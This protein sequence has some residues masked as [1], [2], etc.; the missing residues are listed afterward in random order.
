MFGVAVLLTSYIALAVVIGVK[1]FVKVMNWLVEVGRMLPA[2]SRKRV[3]F[4]GFMVFV[5]VMALELVVVLVFSGSIPRLLVALTFAVGPIEEGVKL[6]PFLLTR[7]EKLLRWRIALSTALAFALME[8]LLYGVL[9]ILTGNPLGALF[10]VVV[11]MFHV[12]WTAIAL[13]GAL[14]GSLPVGYL[15]ASV[16]HS[17]YDAPVLLALAGVGLVVVIPITLV[18]GVA[19]LLTY[20]GINGAFGAAYSLGR[21]TI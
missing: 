8:G 6:L 4:Y 10:R 17:L 1:I 18:S 13:E 11:V 12:A 2:V 15:K 5:L 20:R 19:V 21:A 3:L 9:L 7:G 16:L 14:N